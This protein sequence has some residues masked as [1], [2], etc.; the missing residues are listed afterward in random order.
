M[1]EPAT[2]FRWP[3]R[4][5]MEDTDAG[6]IVFY[7]NYLKFM[8]RARTEFLRQLGF[9]RN[10]I[11]SEQQMFVVH[12]VNAEYKASARLDQLL[13]VEARVMQLKRTSVIL[14]QNI[15]C[16]A[17]LLCAGHVKLAC[18]NRE[19]MRPL[20]IPPVMHRALEQSLRT[21]D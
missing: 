5:Y 12:S 9:D 7:V 18:V 8:E 2:D 11:F 1:T 6:G 4:V 3:V 15:Y 13:S 17:E 16:N 21:Q 19:T 20:P 10:G 14:R